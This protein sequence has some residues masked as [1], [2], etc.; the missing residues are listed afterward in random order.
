MLDLHIHTNYSDGDENVISLLRKAEKNKLSVISFTDHNTC[1]AYNILKEVYNKNHYKV[2]IITGCEIYTCIESY[3][4]ELLAYGFNLDAFVANS[5]DILELNYL[6]KIN[7]FMILRVF[8]ICEKKGIIVRERN[9]NNYLRK[10]HPSILLH[11]EITKYQENRKFFETEN[12]WKD[13]TKFYRE[14]ICNNNSVFFVDFSSV[15]PHVL[16]V[17]NIIHKT[18]GFVFLPH[19]FEY[20]RNSINILYKLIDKYKIDGIECFYPSYTKE[21]MDF[22]LNLC[23]DKDY[24]VSAGSDFHTNKKNMDIGVDIKEYRNKFKWIDRINQFK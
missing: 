13:S 7:E 1:E 9:I 20:G 21:Q 14:C 19:V 2:K 4:I 17:I 23:C 11:R 16:C 5:K 8:D 3:P 6:K 24:F 22:L 18:G 10:K 12:L 15:L